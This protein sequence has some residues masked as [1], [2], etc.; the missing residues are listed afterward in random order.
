MCS[1]TDYSTA[2][3]PVS[4]FWDAE[5]SALNNYDPDKDRSQ[6]LSTERAHM[7]FVGK[8]YL[9]ID[10]PRMKFD[11][12][13]PIGT[14]VVV[15]LEIKDLRDICPTC[16]GFCYGKAVVGEIN[17]GADTTTFNLPY[18]MSNCKGW[19]TG[20]VFSNTAPVENNVK[21][22]FHCRKGD[23][24]VDMVLKPYEV[25]SKPIEQLIDYTGVLNAT[26][27]ATANC[28]SVVLI[29]DGAQCYGYVLK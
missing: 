6:L 8:P 7:F 5:G 1:N 15:Q 25:V 19:W 14:K 24:T 29:G 20:I 3:V 11:S 17:Y 4:Y 2:V 18:L 21:V 28:E 27:F 23:V 13:V 9:L 16:V 26:L 10:V 22:I 12:S